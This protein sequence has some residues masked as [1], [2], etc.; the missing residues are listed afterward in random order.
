VGGAPPLLVE[1]RVARATA[2]LGRELLG[3]REVDPVEPL[4]GLGMHERERT[5][6]PSAH[7]QRHDQFRP[8]RDG[9][10]W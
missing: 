6:A 8:Y 5:Q 9:S 10:R 1:P 7:G 2:A 3:K 4:A